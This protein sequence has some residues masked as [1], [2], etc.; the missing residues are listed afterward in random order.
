MLRRSQS[1][2]RPD[3]D[4]GRRLTRAGLPPGP[5]AFSL[6]NIGKV[7]RDII[8]FFRECNERYGDFVTVRVGPTRRLLLQDPDVIEQMLSR[9]NR[10]FVK[11][12]LVRSTR[13]LGNGLLSSDGETWIRQRRLAQPSFQ[14]K[15]IEGYGRVILEH[16][17]RMLAG[18]ADGE[19]RDVYASF[20]HL[21]L[22]IIA[23]IIFGEDAGPAALETLELFSFAFERFGK[24][25]KSP[26]PLPDAFPSP[27][28]I[29][30]LKAIQRIDAALYTLIR[31]RREGG[32]EPR[33]DLLT[34]LCRARMEDGS[35]LDERQIRDEIAS[36]IAA[37]HDANA[38]VVTWAALLLAEYPDRQRDLQLELDTV[39]AG[40]APTV[41]D[42]HRLPLTEAIVLEAMRLY[43]PVWVFGREPIRD[44]D[45][46]G[47][48]I[49]KGTSI[50]VCQYLLHRDRRFFDDPDS[51]RPER[52]L[53]GSPRCHPY[54]FVPFGAGP[55]R[56]IGESLA[57]MESILVLVSLCQRFSLTKAPSTQVE[58]ATNLTL[59]PK[60][61]LVLS[62]S[63]RVPVPLAAVS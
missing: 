28:N 36:F 59:I 8:G 49:K 63:K 21:T 14:A 24:R 41:A 9:N 7:Q 55:R 20:K 5:S 13:M 40:R 54:A 44:C 32:D 25:L 29:R 60:G 53:P 62:M 42:V 4:G 17:E 37:G 6:G 46:G 45:L 15:A 27:G 57:M 2:D 33:K 10:D 34:H 39:L 50:L 19:A 31:L 51:F 47:Y 43:P 3:G 11:P 52:W 18:W 58:L 56:C 26:V 16:T 48:R 12:Y 38:A 30:L 23:Q 22:E 61:G 1:G 35:L